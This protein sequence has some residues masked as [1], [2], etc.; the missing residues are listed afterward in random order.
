MNLLLICRDALENSIL[1]NLL[2][3]ME[4]KKEGNEVDVLFTEESLAALAGQVLDWSP[5][6]RDRDTRTQ[7]AKKATEQELP[8]YPAPTR[9]FPA[10]DTMEL[11]KKAKAAGIS[12]YACPMWADFLDLQG[13][14]P[15]EITGL[16]SSA[17]LEVIEKAETII[18]NF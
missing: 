11:M 7:I 4:V 1:S 16:D 13:K 5:L 15:S 3:A 14:L 8:T 12:L 2:V 9:G 18:G 10:I 17:F 6:L